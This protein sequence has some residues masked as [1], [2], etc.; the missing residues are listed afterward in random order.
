MMELPPRARCV[1]LVRH[2]EAERLGAPHAMD[3]DVTARGRD[4]IAALQRATADLAIDAIACSE[5][6]RARRTAEAI[7]AGR[8]VAP[9]I[10]P[11]WN[12][13]H[14]VGAWREHGPRE[15]DELVAARFYRPD[16][17][18]AIGE[19]L[20]AM[21]RRVLAAWQRLLE[22]PGRRLLLVAHNSVLGTLIQALLGLPEDAERTSMIAYPHAAISE[23]WLLDRDHDPELPGR[24]TVAIR[25]A[26]AGHLPPALVTR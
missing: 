12:E 10:D 9:V 3:P 26:D 6:I 1:Y 5:L 21:H 2:A 25:I 15:V 4:Q 22:L 17:R 7:A 19:S 11:G 24:I 14:T 18:R 16:D 20:R 13:F 23:L 8:G